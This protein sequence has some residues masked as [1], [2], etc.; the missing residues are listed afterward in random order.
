MPAVLLTLTF[1]VQALAVQTNRIELI[2]SAA[3]LSRAAARGEAVP[4]AKVEGNLVC[5]QLEISEPFPIAEKQCARQ[6]GS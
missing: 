5:V 2:Y 3:Q 1:A 6:L 4:N